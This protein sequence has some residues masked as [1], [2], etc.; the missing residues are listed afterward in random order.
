MSTT[1][2]DARQMCRKRSAIHAPPGGAISPLGRSGCFA[3]ALSARRHL[4]DV[5]ETKQQLVLGQRLGASAEA[6][7]L[8]LFDDLFQPLGT[9]ALG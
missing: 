8:Q 4:F 7:T 2:L 5:F 6:M 9:G 3:F 1:N